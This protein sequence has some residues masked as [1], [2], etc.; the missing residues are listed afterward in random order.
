[1]PH[2]V[3]D[4]L[5]FG[6]LHHKTDFFGLSLKINGVHISAAKVDFA[7]LLT[8]GSNGRFKPA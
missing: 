6:I 7:L 2:L 1:M 4:Y 8:F 3:R 5:T